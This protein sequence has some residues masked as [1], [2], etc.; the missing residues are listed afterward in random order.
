MGETPTVVVNIL[1]IFPSS[2]KTK[3]IQLKMLDYLSYCVKNHLESS[4]VSHLVYFERHNTQQSFIIYS[5]LSIV[6]FHLFNIILFIPYY[7]LSHSQIMS[8]SLDYCNCRAIECVDI[9]QTITTTNIAMTYHR[10][11]YRTASTEMESSIDPD[12]CCSCHYPSR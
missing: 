5:L 12:Q 3:A 7:S 9:L 8:P 10:T 4:S 1:K 6:S 2:P 11:S